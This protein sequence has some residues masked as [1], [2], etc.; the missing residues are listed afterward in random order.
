M[1]ELALTSVVVH[2][3]RCR[4]AQQA[5]VADVARASESFDDETSS[6]ALTADGGAVQLVAVAVACGVAVAAMTPLEDCNLTKD[7]STDNV[8]DVVVAGVD[9]VEP[10]RACLAVKRAIVAFAM[11]GDLVETVL[12]NSKVV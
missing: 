1:V 3:I 12:S 5:V 11:E 2:Y 8:V 9:A 6:N 7:T 4:W 10:C